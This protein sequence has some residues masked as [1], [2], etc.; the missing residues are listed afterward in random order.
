MINLFQTVIKPTQGIESEFFQELLLQTRFTQR[1]AQC[2]INRE[3]I[4]NEIKR[5]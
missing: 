4:L 5:Y 2:S 1:S 3:A